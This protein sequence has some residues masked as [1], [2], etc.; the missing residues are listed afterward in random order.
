VNRY[1]VTRPDGEIVT[2]NSRRGVIFVRFIY[3]DFENGGWIMSQHGSE[4]AARTGPNQTP[5]WSRFERH[6]REAIKL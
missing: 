4:K 3:L 2:F 6:I 1:Q 5:A